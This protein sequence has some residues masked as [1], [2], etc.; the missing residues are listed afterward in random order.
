MP[1]GFNLILDPDVTTFRRVKIATPSAGTCVLAGTPVDQSHTASA[2]VDV[3]VSTASSVT[4]A[5]YGVTQET[6]YAGQT[7]VL[8]AV[9]TPR[10]FWSCEVS[11]SATTATGSASTSYNNLRSVLG[12]EPVTVGTTAIP[13]GDLQYL[14]NGVNTVPAGTTAN[15]TTIYNATTDV[16]G[17]TGLFEQLGIVSTAISTTRIV[18]R[19]LVEH[20]A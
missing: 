2:S 20:A 7:S 16:T 1:Q 11:T 19:F 13:A 17:T 6:I 14:S 12:Y 10:Q 15:L 9:I 4:S 8:I 18:G 5:I 3:V